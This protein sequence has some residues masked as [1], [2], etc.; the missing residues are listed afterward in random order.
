MAFKKQTP[1]ERAAK[2][3]TAKEALRAGLAALVTGDD[4]RA[5]LEGVAKNALVRCSPRR[6]SFANQ[7][8]VAGAAA[9]RDV[10]G[11]AVATAKAWRKYGRHPALGSKAVYILQPLKWSKERENAQGEKERVAGVFFRPLPVFLVGQTAGDP[12]PPPPVVPRPVAVDDVPGYAQHVET[13]RNV[14]LT[15]EGAPVSSFEVRDSLPGDPPGAAG[16]YVPRTRAIV[17]LRS[18]NQAQVFKTCVHETAHALM[19]GVTSREVHDYPWGEVEAESVAFVVCK[20]LGLDTSSYSFPYVGTWATKSAVDKDPLRLVAK[21]G[22][23]I[24]DAVNVILDALLGT[25]EEGE[26]D[27]EGDAAEAAE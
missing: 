16:W 9:A 1:E 8:I 14:A 26:G 17:V 18:S 20:V 7:M 27:G 3:E 6:L 4:W 25:C 5:M 22:K 19:H 24:V 11:S 21:S 15:I 10:D 2:V 13:L 12:L 23:R